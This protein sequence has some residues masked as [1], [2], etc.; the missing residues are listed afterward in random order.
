[1]HRSLR[2]LLGF[3][4]VLVSVLACDRRLEP[5]VALEDEPAR[6]ERP[7]RVPGLE[8][9]APRAAMPMGPPETAGARSGTTASDGAPIRGRV[10]A[11]EGVEAGGGGVLF[12]VARSG[13]GGGPPLAVKRLAVGPFPVEFEIGPSD[14]MMQGRP[15]S[16]A[17][18]LS[19]RVDRDGNATTRDPSEP[20]AE[21]AAPVEPGT[22]GVELRLE[23]GKSAPAGTTASDGA[24]IRGRVVAGEG[25]EAGGGG[26]L[27]VIARSGAGG[28][29]PLAVKRLAVGPFPVEFE[30]GPSDVMMQ[31]RPFSGAITLSARVDR[32]GNAM[33]R[34][35]SEPLAELAA[36]VEP[37]TDGVELRLEIG[38]AAR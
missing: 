25:V 6:L 38:K 37:G 18:T 23:I 31:G 32:D 30:I 20:L 26:V 16:G 2:P 3:I 12:V 24:P 5:F 1:M 13:A 21:L 8:N 4:P 11:G 19:A 29:P 9:P 7:V 33:T 15:F 36:P 14:V 22:N 35:P 28:G 10:V 27:F 17:I 34:D